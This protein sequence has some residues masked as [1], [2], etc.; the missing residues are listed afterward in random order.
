M[1]LV[2]H[3]CL[4]LGLSL[5]DLTSAVYWTKFTFSLPFFYETCVCIKK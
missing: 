2:R 4:N 3:L 5:A 1:T